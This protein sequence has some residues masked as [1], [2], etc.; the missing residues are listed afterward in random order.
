MTKSFFVTS[1]FYDAETGDIV[2]AGSTFE[3][4]A[5]REEVLRAAGVIGKEEKPFPDHDAWPKHVGGGTF[6]LSNGERVKSKEAA[7]EAEGKLKAGDMDAK[8]DNGADTGAS[9]VDGGKEASKA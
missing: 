2:K 8:A 9:D 3:A 6:E 4:D 7:E 5:E 1:D